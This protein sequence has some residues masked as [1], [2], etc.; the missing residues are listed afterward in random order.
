MFVRR[1][2]DHYLPYKLFLLAIFL[3]GQ[4]VFCSS[5]YF[6]TTNLQITGNHV[7]SVQELKHF[8]GLQEGENLLLLRLS[9]VE[10][11]LKRHTWVQQA[12]VKFVYPRKLFIRV[13]ERFPAA[14]LSP[15][16]TAWY[17]A[18]EDGMVLLH[19]NKA[20]RN[21]LPL[22]MVDDPIKI[23]EKFS[24][25]QIKGALE[26]L[27]ELSPQERVK[28]QYFA[29]HHDKLE[30]YYGN[31]NVLVKFGSLNHLP[32]KIRILKSLLSYLEKRGKVEKV[33]YI[34]FTRSKVLVKFE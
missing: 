15:T 32:K 23:G 33:Q 30:M 29:Y 16:G 26:C 19:L 3:T 7:V 34:D 12:K 20:Q 17:G 21:T 8:A 11:R 28:I 5:E 25:Q 6:N 24:F 4:L 2:R 22:I 18:A 10:K 1:K 13:T 31:H 9:G 27:D 14:A